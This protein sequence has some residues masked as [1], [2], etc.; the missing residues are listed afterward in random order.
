MKKL[1]TLITLLIISIGTNAQTQPFGKVDTADL[2]LTTCNFEKGAN[3]EVL[4]SKCDM[5]M[6][7]NGIKI[8][9]HKRIK[10][11][12]MAAHDLGDVAIDFAADNLIES[13][14]DL[15]AETFN[16][17]NG[18]IT[19]SKVDKQS[20]YKRKNDRWTSHYSFSLPDMRA[21][22]I[23]E[24]SYSRFIHYTYNPPSWYF[25][26]K[27]PVRYSE[28]RLTVPKL[29]SFKIRPCTNQPL[30]ANTDTL[31]A[32][33]NIR[34]LPEEPFMSSWYSNLQSVSFIFVSGDGPSGKILNKDS[35]W[36]QV[37]ASL[38]YNQSYGQQ[39]KNK[40]DDEEQLIAAT[41]NMTVPEKIAFIFN[42]VRDT[43]KCSDD[44][45][46]LYIHQQLNLAWKFRS[47]NA[48]DI[49]MILCRLL[50]QAGVP[51]CPVAVSMDRDDRVEPD[52]V[53]KF[54]FDRTIAYATI[55]DRHYILDAS[56]KEN[57]WFIAPA[58]F[59]NTYGLY[60]DVNALSA[61]LM[62]LEDDSPSKDVVLIDAELT[63]E[64]TMNGNAM[65]N[66]FGY[67]KPDE[68]RLYK[69]LGKKKYSEYLCNGNNN[70]HIDS[71]GLQNILKD[72]LAL[73][74]N[75]K[76]GLKLQSA[77]GQYIYFSP[78]QFTLLKDN[79]FL[80]ESRYS[81]VD[82]NFRR[83][84]S[85]TGRFKIPPGYTAYAIPKNISLLMPDKSISFKRILD[86]QNGYVVVHY[87]LNYNKSYFLPKEYSGLRE[88][89]KKMYEMLNE[90]IILKKT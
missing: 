28:C 60:M 7:I 16:L 1:Y 33:G 70:L 27:I 89:Y 73:I 5:H 82:L 78:N 50:S 41:K 8:Q 74:R 65:I 62:F 21:G 56:D 71:I 59:L 69:M 22:S 18:K 4:F 46:T 79:P 52:D 87:N 90:E 48:S 45:P 26:D 44:Y 57:Q 86:V 35:T 80:S 17:T 10:I 42:K 19:I 47:G 81:A 30:L 23:I 84:H 53:R 54:Q 67:N 58:G 29:L 24:Y 34:S 14:S 15:Q 40:L 55:N 64:G 20:F 88:F 9:Y 13:I 77:D 6:G 49:N 32:M 3:A 39:L 51:T 2:R 12:N 72:T 61:G 63:P 36:Q 38:I 25:Q 83:D 37:G 68:L 85:I 75:I 31:V 11:F 76:F 43:M 66:S